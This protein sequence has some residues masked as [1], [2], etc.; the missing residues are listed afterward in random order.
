MHGNA[1]KQ[2]HNAKNEVILKRL[3]EFGDLNSAP[4]G[5]KEG[6]QGS[7]FFNPKSTMKQTPDKKDAHLITATSVRNNTAGI[8]YINHDVPNYKTPTM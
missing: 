3:L 1:G 8:Y 4:N 5:R 6:S 2:S 7:T